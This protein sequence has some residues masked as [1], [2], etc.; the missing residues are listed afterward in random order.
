LPSAD[1][2]LF[3][4]RGA[5]NQPQSSGEQKSAAKT[6]SE[7]PQNNKNQTETIEDGEDILRVETNLVTVPVSVL[8]KDGKYVPDL[9]REDFHLFENSV[10]QEIAHF[11]RSKAVSRKRARRFRPF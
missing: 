4:N 8:D 5:P 3:R 2:L 7:I 10:E 1:S 11:A 6:A 9:R